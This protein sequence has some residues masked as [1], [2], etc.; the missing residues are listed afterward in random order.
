MCCLRPRCMRVFAERPATYAHISTTAECLREQRSQRTRRAIRP[1][2]A[3]PSP[4]SWTLALLAVREVSCQ[5]NGAIHKVSCSRSAATNL[6]FSAVGLGRP[7]CPLLARHSQWP[8]TRSILA[9]EFPHG[10]SFTLRSCI[11]A[12]RSDCVFETEQYV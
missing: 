12:T 10:P 2:P 6:I 11:G 1:R 8:L 3:L 5:A 4:F 7:L 9:G